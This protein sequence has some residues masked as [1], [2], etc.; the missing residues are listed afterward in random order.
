MPTTAA[1][2]SGPVPATA[3]SASVLSLA[4]HGAGSSGSGAI[5]NQKQRDSYPFVGEQGQ[6]I[7]VRAKRTSGV[8]LQPRIELLDPSGV[9]EVPYIVPFGPELLVERNLASTGSYTIVISASQGVGPYSVTWA[10]DRFGQLANGGQVN[11]ELTDPDQKDRF[12][13]EARQS[14]L[15]T[16][17]VQRTSGV[18][19]EPWIQLIDPSGAKES[20]ANGYGNAQVTLESKLASSGTYTLVVGGQNT[21]PYLV[22]LSIQ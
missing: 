21:G 7:E 19:L 10:L 8:T 17:R 15:L 16:A 20:S 22:T 14:Q 13:F 11:A 1:A 3:T 12:R 5:T 2:T 6:L 18:S 9:N 4:P